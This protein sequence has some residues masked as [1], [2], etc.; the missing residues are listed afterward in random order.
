MSITFTAA[1]LDGAGILVPVPG[2]GELNVHNGHA[3][4]LLQLLG[5]PVEADGEAPAEDFLGRVL[6]ARAL[7]DITTDDEHG[8]PPITEGRITWGGR[9]PGELAGHLATLHRLA[10]WAADRGARVVW[11]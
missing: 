10:A 9:A 7:L 6:I 1:A 11:G 3:A 5:L 8:R 2:S 4:D